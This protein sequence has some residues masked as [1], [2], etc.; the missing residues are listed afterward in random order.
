MCKSWIY[1]A[2]I[3]SKYALKRSQNFWNAKL[4]QI[5]CVG[6]CIHVH[7][8][9]QYR[10][11]LHPYCG[12]EFR[13]AGNIGCV[14]SSH[15]QFLTLAT[16]CVSKKVPFLLPRPWSIHTGLFETW[17]LSLYT[18]GNLRKKKK[19][20]LFLFWLGL[21][22]IP[23]HVCTHKFLHKNKNPSLLLQRQPCSRLPQI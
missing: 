19:R 23:P 18:R 15:S 22:P 17:R 2:S 21:L 8:H 5:F 14:Q 16:T 6:Y 20:N 4:M 9:G 12:N 7:I 3:M 10:G 11:M 13:G 1:R